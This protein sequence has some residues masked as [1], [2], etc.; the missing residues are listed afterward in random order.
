VV[1]LARLLAQRLERA[2]RQVDGWAERSTGTVEIANTRDVLVRYEAT[3]VGAK[4]V[5]PPL[6]TSIT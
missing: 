1:D 4:G 2:G 3:L 5:K 6:S